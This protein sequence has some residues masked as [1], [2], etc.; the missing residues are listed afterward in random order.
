MTIAAVILV[1][2]DFGDR[3]QW[4][5]LWSNFVIDFNDQRLIVFKVERIIQKWIIQKR[6]IV[7]EQ[8]IAH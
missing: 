6:S 3:F 2:I 5:L 8:S 4:F 7:K 1:F